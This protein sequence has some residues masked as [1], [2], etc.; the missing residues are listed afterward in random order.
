MPRE[1]PYHLEFKYEGE[2]L[3]ARGTHYG[4]E[5]AKRGMKSAKEEITA[6][7]GKPGQWRIV[8]GRAPTEA[9]FRRMGKGLGMP[10]NW[11]QLAVFTAIGVAAFYFLKEK[12]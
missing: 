3:P 10:I 11:S 12:D 6:D 2:W 8:P 1:E 9:E 5:A 4:K 7:T